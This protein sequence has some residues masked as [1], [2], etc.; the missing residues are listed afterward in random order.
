M[1]D[2]GLELN[3]TESSMD[4]HSIISDPIAADGEQPQSAGEDGLM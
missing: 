4:Q 3:I 1:Q 2:K